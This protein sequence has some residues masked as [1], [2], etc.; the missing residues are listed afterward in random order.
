MKTTSYIMIF[1]VLATAL[2]GQNAPAEPTKTAA[3]EL[4]H[5]AAPITNEMAAAAHTG[6]EA[7]AF[8]LEKARAYTGK[9]EDAVGKAVDLTIKEA[10][11][12]VRQFLTWRAWKHGIYSATYLLLFLV[13]LSATCYVLYRTLAKKY[14]DSFLNI[15][16]S[17]CGLILTT[18]AG[19]VSIVVLTEA[20]I[21]QAIL[22]TE[23][24]VAPRIYLIEQLTQM[25][26]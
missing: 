22:L 20:L 1:A 18:I 26:K 14:E 8:M 21:P 2:F 5:Q 6:N 15:E 3:Q 17:P 7:L 13:F 10:P 19:V 11:E 12:T 24:L 4:A 9:A 23:V 25:L 16:E